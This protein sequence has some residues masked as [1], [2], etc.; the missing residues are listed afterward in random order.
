MDVQR[1]YFDVADSAPW[2]MDP[3][4]PGVNPGPKR[5]AVVIVIIVVAV[6]GPCRENP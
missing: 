2:A 4:T 3:L 6:T 5:A 1:F